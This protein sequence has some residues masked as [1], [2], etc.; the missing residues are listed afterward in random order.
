MSE[1]I[2]PRN[3]N[4]NDSLGG[5][6]G[7]VSRRS[8]LTAGAATAALAAPSIARAQAPI[9][10][11]MATSWPKGAPGVGVNAQR[12]ADMITAMSGGRLSVQLFGAGELVPPFEVFDAVSSGAVQCGH[13][14]PYYWQGKD[15]A[16]H[17]FTGVPFG[18]TASEHAAWLHFGGGQELW[19]QAYAPFGVVPFLAGSSGPQAGGWFRKEISGLDDFKGLKMRIAGLGGEV[20]RRLGVS[21]VLLPPG[22][23]FAAM[24]AGTIDAAEWVGPWNDLAFGLNRVASYYY[25]PAFHELGPALELTVN[26]AAFEAL[27]DDL[28]EIVKRAAM[29]S[30][31]ESLA[32]FTFHNI[33]SFRPLLDALGPDGKPIELRTF[34]DD[35][36]AA[37]AREAEGALADIAA[38]SPHAKDVYAS[39]TAFR[40]KAH[41]YARH[42]DLAALAMREK[43]LGG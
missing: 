29:A 30:S 38:G 22:E 21:V 18:L 3:A 28:K 36:V 8:V 11:K 13:A 15:P 42:S 19:Q 1:P 26:A 23:I 41:D 31:M 32:D 27:D 39:F 37:L 40:A 9:A 20:M 7:A 14:T 16:F 24:Q 34:S 33:E 35:I 12:L 17:F 4:G 10:W 6:T 5:R 2:T 25:M 43:A